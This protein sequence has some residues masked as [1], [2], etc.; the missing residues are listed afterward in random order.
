MSAV[1]VNDDELPLA[2]E[3]NPHRRGAARILKST[4]Q[5]RFLPSGN[6]LPSASAE[7]YHSPNPSPGLPGCTTRYRGREEQLRSDDPAQPL[8]A[9]LAKVAG[10]EPT[11]QLFS[12]AVCGPWSEPVEETAV[13]AASSRPRRRS[14]GST[15]P[16]QPS[17][18]T[19]VT[20]GAGGVDEACSRS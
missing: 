11:D 14:S 9:H 5:E 18:G 15:A 1:Q 10:A 3:N 16:W 6:V 7:G 20:E 12:V 17:I 19:R 8:Q 4:L 2:F 13:M